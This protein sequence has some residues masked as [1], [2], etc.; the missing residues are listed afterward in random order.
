M[1]ETITLS[2]PVPDGYTFFMILTAAWVVTV[3]II[4]LGKLDYPQEGWR[5]PYRL[6]FGRS[7]LFPIVFAIVYTAWTI[8]PVYF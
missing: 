1:S 7:G 3:A 2:L 6:P 8:H 5:W 4:C